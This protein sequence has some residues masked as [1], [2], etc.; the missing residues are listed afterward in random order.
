MRRPEVRGVSGKTITKRSNGRWWNY[1]KLWLLECF[2]LRNKIIYNSER[3]FYSLANSCDASL[4]AHPHRY[5]LIYMIKHFY[6]SDWFNLGYQ[7]MFAHVPWFDLIWKTTK[8]PSDKAAEKSRST[9]E[10]KEKTE[11]AIPAATK[12]P[13]TLVWNYLMVLRRNYKL[14]SSL[15][16]AD[17]L[18]TTTTTKL[19]L[20]VFRM[21]CKSLQE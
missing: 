3:S 1:S 20:K 13:Q 5:T 8:F 21:A 18:T 4:H 2:S 14:H 10:I 15:R 11:N 9:D 16:R 12:K 6:H 17:Y 19:T 7:F